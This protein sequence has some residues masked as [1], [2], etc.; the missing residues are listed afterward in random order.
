MRR[1]LTAFVVVLATAGSCINTGTSTP[2]TLVLRFATG[3]SIALGR[4]VTIAR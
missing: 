3:V 1:V 4:S 2:V